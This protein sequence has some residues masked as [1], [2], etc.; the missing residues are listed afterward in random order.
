MTLKDLKPGESGKV[1][2][3][4]QAG[5]VR[6]RIMEMGVTPGVQVKVVKK[7]PLGDPVEINEGDMN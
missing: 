1:M 7:A 2:S 4:G 3:I 6:K 5:P